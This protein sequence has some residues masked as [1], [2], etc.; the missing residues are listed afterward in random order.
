MKAHVET[1]LHRSSIGKRADG[2]MVATPGGNPRNPRSPPRRIA[3]HRDSCAANSARP[4]LRNAASLGPNSP[5]RPS[6]TP[7][8]RR[9]TGRANRVFVACHAARDW[10]ARRKARELVDRCESV[11]LCFP[12]QSTTRS[13]LASSAG[14]AAR[15]VAGVAYWLCGGTGGESTT[16][17]RRLKRPVV[18]A[19]QPVFGFGRA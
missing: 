11:R 17:P 2:P 12:W 4:Q 18:Q 16:P 6:A 7:G 1:F 8:E 14:R 3:G 15:R 9:M 10:K 13:N 5:R 19:M